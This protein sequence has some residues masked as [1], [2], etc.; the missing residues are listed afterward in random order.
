RPAPSPTDPTPTG[1]DGW[2]GSS[3]ASSRCSR[4][5]TAEPAAPAVRPVLLSWALLSLLTAAPYARGWLAPPPGTAFLGFFY[6]VDDQYNYFSYV[7][8]AEAGALLFE[9]PLGLEPHPRRLVNLEWWLVGRL[10]ALLG[11]RPFLAWRLLA[12]A[13][14]FGLLAGI[15]RWLRSAG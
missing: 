1:W 6:F 7:R 10:S 8:K 5:P 2:S 3:R 9:N 11:G 4:P 12:L 13:A 14:A 15:D